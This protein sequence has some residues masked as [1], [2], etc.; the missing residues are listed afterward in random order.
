M[1]PRTFSRRGPFN[2]NRAA[3]IEPLALRIALA[4]HREARTGVQL[5]DDH[6]ARATSATDIPRALTFAEEKGWIVNGGRSGCSVLW[7]PGTAPTLD[8]IAKVRAM[9]L[10]DTGRLRSSVPG[11]ARAA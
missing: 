10:V 11:L 9:Q 1:S 8:E 4:V 6:A 7:T 2:T 5:R 3:N